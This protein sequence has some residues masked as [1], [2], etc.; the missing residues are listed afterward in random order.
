MQPVALH[1]SDRA[2][3]SPTLFRHR[4]VKEQSDNQL[5]QGEYSTLKMEIARSSETSMN[6]QLTIQRYIPDSNTPHSQC[7]ENLK[8]TE[9]SPGS[10]DV[11]LRFAWQS[12]WAN[13]FILC[14]YYHTFSFTFQISFSKPSESLFLTHILCL[15]H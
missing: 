1:C 4:P 12:E 14:C 15:V 10:V 2:I 13:R 11:R 5:K 6:F 9:I 3:R 8:S 7:C